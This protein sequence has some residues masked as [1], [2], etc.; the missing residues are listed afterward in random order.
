MI[1]AS[2]TTQLLPEHRTGFRSTDSKKSA[3]S[4]VQGLKAR[5]L[6]EGYRGSQPVD[7]AKLV[8]TLTT[9]SQWV[10]E[11][12]DFFES[13]DLNPVLCSG[14]SCVVADARIMLRTHD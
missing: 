7:M 8:A 6:L 1:R 9:F 12:A 14:K 5:R 3:L 11:A 13:V 4:M 10:M 2:A